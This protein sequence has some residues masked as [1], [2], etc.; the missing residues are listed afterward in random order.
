MPSGVFES[1]RVRPCGSYRNALGTLGKY[2]FMG[3]TYFMK[4]AEGLLLR[5]QLEAK[6]KQLEPLKIQG[7]NG[8]YETKIQRRNVSENVDEVTAQVPK[9]KLEDITKT[10]DHY[11]TQLRKLDTAIQQANWAHDLVYT[12]ETLK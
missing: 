4:I 2:L 1:L 12:E 11:A 3:N 8:V 5:K 10:Y 6:V 7:E 9:I